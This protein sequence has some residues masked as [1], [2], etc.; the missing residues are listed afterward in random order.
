ME[1]EMNMR[2]YFAELLYNAMQSNDRIFLIVGDLGY[3]LF[4]KIRKD[5]PERFINAGAA[6]QAMM[7][8]GVGLALEGKIPFVYSITPFLLWRTAETIRNYINHEGIAVRLIGSGRNNDYKHDGFSHWAGDD[9][10]L[11]DIF[12]NIKSLWPKNNNELETIFRYS[13]DD[14]FSSIEPIYINLKR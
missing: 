8:I 10:M 6:E 1:Q 7:G 14:I 4:D 5:F 9:K 12:R 3:G 11:M 13:I 2:K